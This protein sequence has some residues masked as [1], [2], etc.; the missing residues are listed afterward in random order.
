MNRQEDQIVPLGYRLAKG[1]FFHDIG[2]RL[3]LIRRFPLKTVS[4]HSLWKPVVALLSQD[5]F[6]A[7]EEILSLFE[8]GRPRRV[9]QMLDDLVLK[10][11]LEQHGTAKLVVFPKV[12]VIIPVRNRPD[13]I[14]ACLLSLQKL[15]LPE[16]EIGNHCGG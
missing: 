14:A 13:E 4:L 7:V 2:D 12:S 15:N 9:E 10:G 16:R 8:T 11:F 6:A 1:V 5:R 3:F